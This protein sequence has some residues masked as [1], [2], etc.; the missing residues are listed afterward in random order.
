MYTYIIFRQF[1]LQETVTRS[2]QNK[3]QRHWVVCRPTYQMLIDKLQQKL[4]MTASEKQYFDNNI[5][6]YKQI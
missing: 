2:N 6:M 4:E 1:F 5:I 3:E